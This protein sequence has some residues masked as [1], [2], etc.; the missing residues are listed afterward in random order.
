M[1]W[2]YIWIA[3]A[4]LTVVFPMGG[5]AGSCAHYGEGEYVVCEC[6]VHGVCEGGLWE[7]E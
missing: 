1:C 2:V 4:S 6:I 5:R 7:D 3:A